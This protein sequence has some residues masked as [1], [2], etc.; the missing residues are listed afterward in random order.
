MLK[1]KKVLVRCCIGCVLPKIHNIIGTGN[2]FIM[3][4]SIKVPEQYYDYCINENDLDSFLNENRKLLIKYKLL[5][6]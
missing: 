3:I 6:E 4:N 5:D 1:K 2:Y